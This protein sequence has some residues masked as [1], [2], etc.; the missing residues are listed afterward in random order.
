MFKKLLSVGVLFA[1]LGCR[2]SIKQ[3]V[4]P[5]GLIP[6]GYT[7]YESGKHIPRFIM[8]TLCRLEGGDFRLADEDNKLAV[9][10]SDVRLDTLAT[11][12]KLRFMLVGES[13]CVIVYQEGGYGIHD[14]IYLFNYRD[15]LSYR[16]YFSSKEVLDTNILKN[17]RKQDTIPGRWQ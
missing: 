9:N 12:K 17:L 13:T 10:L 2:N 16:K 8:D 14:V 5:P 1:S 3:K 15:R 4:R 6:P 7:F 11:N